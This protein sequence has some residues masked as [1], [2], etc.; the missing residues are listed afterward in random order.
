MKTT[1][2]YLTDTRVKVTFELDKSALDDAEQVA[3]KKLSKSV[4][5]PGFRK[6]H[7]PLNVAAKH[8]DAVALSQET[9]ENALS[10]AVA[11]GFISNQLQALE[12]PEVD[13]K[14]YVPGQEL[15]FVAEAEVLPK[16]KLGEYKKLTAVKPTAKVT[17]ADIDEVLDRIQKGFADKEES[18]EAA[19]MGDDVSIDFVGKKD[20]V[21]FDGGTANDYKLA[22]G[23]QSFIPGFEEAI[24]GHKTGD[25][26]SVPLE[27]PTEYHSKDLAG[28]KVVFDVTLNRVEESVLPELN[29]EFAAKVGEFT[30]IKGLK[31]DVKKEITAQ[32]ERESADK[33]KD[34]LVK[35][36]VEKSTV[37]VPAMLRDD[38]VRSIEQD[39]TQNLLYQGGSFEQYLESKGYADRDEW[40]AK[41]ANEAAE[42]RV[43]A[44]LVLAE[45]SKV[46]KI[47]A[48]ADELAER[49]NTYKTQYASNPDMVKRFD[50]PEIQ[51]SVANELLTAKTLDR[52]VEL[53]A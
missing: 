53:N 17:K 20:D 41:E 49:I 44:G 15:E 50:E 43:K 32:K 27:F 12:R 11:E 23:S 33:Y 26:F 30:D 37:A 8:V 38:Q 46:E 13:V 35:Q 7:V 16:V 36:L 47:E 34:D 9:L 2:K 28:Q 42:L 3:L 4:K 19:K 40:A 25:T 29:D 5:V 45:L 22:L 52:L 10:K 14:K 21:A 18:K 6:G 51:R 39:L 24:V 1:V 48:G 31:D